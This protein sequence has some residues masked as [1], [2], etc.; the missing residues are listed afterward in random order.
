MRRNQFIFL[1]KCFI[2]KSHDYA[3]LK[4]LF[5]PVESSWFNN[6]HIKVD[7]GFLGIAK[8]YLCKKLSIPHKKS[9]KKLLTDE[10]KL[11]NKTFAS[12]RIKVEQR[13]SGLKRY[14]ILS[15]RLRIQSLDFYDKILGVCAGLWNF[16]L[17]FISS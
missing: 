5:K 3:I 16:Y 9:Q 14:R 4:S 11:E 12:E 15:E 1:S 8:D 13:I 10:Q 2:G 7:L 6:H 17:S